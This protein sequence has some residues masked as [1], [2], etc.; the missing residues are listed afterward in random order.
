MTKTEQEKLTKKNLKDAK[1]SGK[2]YLCK[3]CL[4]HRNRGRF[5]VPDFQDDASCPW[6]GQVMDGQNKNFKEI[7]EC[8]NGT[9]KYLN[10]NEKLVYFG[11]LNDDEKADV[12]LAPP[13][14]KKAARRYY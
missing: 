14:P 9:I 12:G 5:I 1:I 4:Q 6:C 3:Y 7:G 2:M 11:K 8:Q 13:K 10:R